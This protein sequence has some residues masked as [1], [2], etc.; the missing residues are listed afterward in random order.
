[1]TK[2][3]FF[4]S[5]PVRISVEYAFGKSMVGVAVVKFKR[6]SQMVVLE[7]T[8]RLGSDKPIFSVDITN[9]LGVT[10]E[11]LIDIDLEFTDAM[12]NRKINA[13]SFTNIKSISTTLD[14]LASD[15]FKRNQAFDFTIAAKLYDNAPV[16]A[17]KP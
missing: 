13:T 3:C 8:I 17:I 15:N 11:E 9:D 2:I 5:F 12:T 4:K 16:I 7:K 14:I 6:F 10:R 1:M